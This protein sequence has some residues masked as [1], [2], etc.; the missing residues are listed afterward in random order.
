MAARPVELQVAGQKV[1]VISS[2]SPEELERLA[3]LVDDKL[4]GIL[5]PGRPLTPQSMLLVALSLAHDIEEERRRVSL[6]RD[7][8]RAA[9]SSL[10]SDVA[11]TL[12]LAEETLAD[13]P[14]A[15]E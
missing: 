8:S 9:I 11:S 3:T 13:A 12:A 10:L 5:P 1:R 14:P 2:A 15:A 4:V 6:I 7:Q